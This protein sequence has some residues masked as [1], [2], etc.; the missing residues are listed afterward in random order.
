MRRDALRRPEGSRPPGARVRRISPFLHTTGLRTLDNLP[1]SVESS[2][3][4]K[5][6]RVLLAIGIARIDGLPVL[7]L[8]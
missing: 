5:S 6:S 3:F 4:T 8:K 7:I 1:Q 2:K